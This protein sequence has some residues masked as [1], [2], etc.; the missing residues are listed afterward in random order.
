VLIAGLREKLESLASMA[1]VHVITADTF[2][3]AASQ[4]EG[5]NCKLVILSEGDQSA[6]KEEY[7]GMLGSESCIAV[8]N[9]RNDASMLQNAAIGIAVIGPEGCAGDSLRNAHIVCN[10]IH[11]VLGLIVNPGRM[12]ATLRS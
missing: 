5:I 3:N 12:K 6:Q 7:V 4:L 8:G 1:E 11:D 9:G 2:G 10:S